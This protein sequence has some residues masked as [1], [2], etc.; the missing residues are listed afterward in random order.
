MIR[1]I[2]PQDDIEIATIIR[3]TF[4][5]FD[6]PKLHTVYDDPSTDHQYE[7][8]RQEPLSVLWVAEEKGRVV[9]SCGVYPTEGLPKGWCE[10][11]KFYVDKEQRGIGIG[12]RLFAKALSSAQHLGYDTAYLETFPQ[13]SEAVGMYRHYGFQFVGHPM[14]NSGHT[15]TSIWMKKKL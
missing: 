6:M 4:D 1:K 9:G 13:F 5:E 7:V 11:V 12:R 8:F 15:A 3:S 2:R 14:G 10:I